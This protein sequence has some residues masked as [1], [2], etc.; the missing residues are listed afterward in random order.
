M[1]FLKVFEKRLRETSFGEKP[2]LGQKDGRCQ[3]R[4]E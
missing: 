1:V 2:S 3:L 4:E